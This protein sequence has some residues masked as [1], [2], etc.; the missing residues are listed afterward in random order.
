MNIVTENLNQIIDAPDG[1]KRLRELILQLAVQGKLVEQ[2]PEDGTAADLLKQIEKAKATD[3]KKR[4]ANG[5]RVQN[6][7]HSPAVSS[8]EMLFSIPASWAWCR[9]EEVCMKI[10]DVDHKMP[11]ACNDGIP[12]VSPRDFTS[13][14]SIDFSSAKKISTDD[15]E[16]LRRKI[17]PQRG[18]IIFP[19]YGTIGVNRMVNT[20]LD[21][22]ASY[23]CAVVKP[24]FRF[25]NTNYLFYY[26]LSS[27]VKS[28]IK[29][30]VNQTTQPNVGV[31]SIKLF[32]L[33]L[34]PL[35]EQKRIVAKV[36]ELMKWCDELEALLKHESETATQ[37]AAA[38]AQCG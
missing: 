34:P 13:D 9:W 29:R 28:E 30:Y 38:V 20:D 32:V 23:S 11:D 2:R 31:K 22:L 37:F 33:P 25:S 5:K 3:Q 16:Q 10:G 21:F 36:D 8:D 26:S 35:P 17:Q 27:V 6:H 7:P 19:R 1:I 12:Y 14:G 18:D 15:F 24:C 4:K